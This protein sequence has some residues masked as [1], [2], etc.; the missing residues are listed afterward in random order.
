MIILYSA[1]IFGL[2]GANN[3]PIGA[4]TSIVMVT[5]LTNMQSTMSLFLIG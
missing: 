3:N 5:V 2:I 1:T 4:N